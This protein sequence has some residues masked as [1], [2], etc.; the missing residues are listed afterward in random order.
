MLTRRALFAGAAPCALLAL[1]GCGTTGG[2]TNINSQVPIWVAALQAIGTEITSVLPQL[3]SFGLTGSALANAQA[4]VAKI[5]TVLSGIGSAS[6]ATQ[7]QSTVATIEGY[8]NTLAP[9]ILPFVSAVPG[10]SI[11]G[12]IVAALPAIETAVNIL[13]TYLTPQAQQ[14]AAT[15]PPPPAGAV[16]GASSSNAYLNMLLN[17]AAQHKASARFHRK[18]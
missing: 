5:E 8:I 7:G 18:R 12:M 10:G 3:Q 9:I 15:A 11:I 14:V 4:I 16:F 6:T 2:T 13:I 1:S 17:A